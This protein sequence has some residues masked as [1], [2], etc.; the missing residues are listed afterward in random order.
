M[1]GACCLSTRKVRQKPSTSTSSTQSSLGRKFQQGHVQV[2]EGV[3]HSVS[4]DC[5][6]AHPLVG[7]LTVRLRE[8]ANV[9]TQHLRHI[10]GCC[11]T[12]S[13]KCSVKT[14]NVNLNSF[15]V[16]APPSSDL[17]F[18][19]LP[20]SATPAT[21]RQPPGMSQSGKT[22]ASQLVTRYPSTFWR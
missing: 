18:A 14:T 22:K 6:G 4:I 11:G 8:T 15:R 3:V 21:S 1:N 17:V 2:R 5:A 13:K 9:S 10:T 12:G 7:W 19:A 16:H 20:N